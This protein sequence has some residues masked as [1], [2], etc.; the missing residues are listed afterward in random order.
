MF[1]N[2]EKPQRAILVAADCGEWDAEVSIDELEELAKSA[3]AEV[4][5][6]VIQQRTEYDRATLVGRGKLEEIKALAEAEDAD[7]LIF[8]HEL[9]AANIRNL[10]EVTGLGVIDR[11]MLI[12]DIFAARAQSRAGRLQV[13]LAQYKYR[14]PRLEGMGKNLSRLGGGIGTR[15]PGESKLESDRRHIRRCIETLERKLDEL[16]ANRELIRSRR[17]KEGITTAAIVGYTNAGKSTLLNRLT[18]AGV[19]SEDKLFATLDPTARS[20]ELP[21]G[22]SIMLVDTVGFVRR[23]PHHLV[24]AFKSTLEETVQADLL[25][26]VCDISSGEADSQTEV[27]RDLLESLGADKIPMLNVL[28]KCDLIEGPLPICTGDCVLV[29]AKTGEG[30]DEMLAKISKML[31]PT[32]IR[33]TVLIPYSEGGF[34]GEIRASGKVFSEEYTP[35]GVLADALIDIKLLPRAQKYQQ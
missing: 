5:A 21:D 10:E 24:E 27:T 25:L 20:L 1:E 26:N 12:L 35:D 16:A 4:I 14:L 28:N 3:G 19:L 23:L 34:L 31:A 6:K 29:S 13:E 7:L 2:E 22:R 30:I 9:T 8:D 11:T 32:Q 17:K 18:N 15:G 33:M